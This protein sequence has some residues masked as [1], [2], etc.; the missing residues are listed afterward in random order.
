MKRIF[1]I[2]AVILSVATHSLAQEAEPV[3]ARDTITDINFRLPEEY[4][5]NLEQNL[6]DWYLRNYAA[7]TPQSH[8]IPHSAIIMFGTMRCSLSGCSRGRKLT[9]EQQVQVYHLNSSSRAGVGKL[10]LGRARW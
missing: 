6:D 3:M 9:K 8:A 5:A 4:V 2:L 1:L 10:S 7:Y